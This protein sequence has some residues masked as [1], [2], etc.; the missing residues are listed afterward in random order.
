MPS[1]LASSIVII[2]LTSTSAFQVPRVGIHSHGPPRSIVSSASMAHPAIWSSFSNARERS[3][4]LRARLGQA[5]LQSAPN[6][7]TA[8]NLLA[9]FLRDALAGALTFLSVLTLGIITP[10]TLASSKARSSMVASSPTPARHQTRD[11]PERARMSPQRSAA[12]TAWL[13]S[14]EKSRQRQSAW[15]SQASVA[16]GP[17]MSTAAPAQSPRAPIIVV[18]PGPAAK[19]TS[20]TALAATVPQLVDAYGQPYDAPKKAYEQR[21]SGK[22]PLNEGL[23]KKA[24]KER[25]DR[26]VAEFI[27][28]F[29]SN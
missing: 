2:A 4:N 13:A 14:Y 3:A 8:P 18:Q 5:C 29:R 27:R 7:R 24:R 15:A 17:T 22:D 1:R 28:K 20:G 12:V 6:M 9:C 16:A 10:Y 19:A 11:E 21:W 23:A 26:E 25:N